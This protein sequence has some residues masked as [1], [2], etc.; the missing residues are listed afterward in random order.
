MKNKIDFKTQTPRSTKFHS[1][2]TN[3]NIFCNKFEFGIVT[4]KYWGDFEARDEPLV[5]LEIKGKQY[6][7]P[8]SEFIEYVEPILKKWKEEYVE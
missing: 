2:V 5:E 1:G 4:S 8:L 7:M 6:Q 3:I